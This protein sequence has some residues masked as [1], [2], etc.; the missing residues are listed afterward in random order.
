MPSRLIC[1]VPG[2]GAQAGGTWFGW[3]YYAGTSWVDTGACLRN[4]QTSHFPRVWS[5]AMQ[6][7]LHV[8][9]EGAS[10]QGMW[11]FAWHAGAIR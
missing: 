6:T 9:A 10:A 1:G 5:D 8:P 2:S 7:W 11:A 3:P 4:I